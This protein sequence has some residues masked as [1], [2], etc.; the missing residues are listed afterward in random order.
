VAWL[1]SRSWGDWG[2]VGSGGE[3]RERGAGADGRS[4]AVLACLPDGCFRA[5]W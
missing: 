5:A 2:E 4:C 1:V 3:V